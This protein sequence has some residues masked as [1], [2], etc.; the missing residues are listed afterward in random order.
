MIIPNPP[1]TLSLDALWISSIVLACL[2]GAETAL[3]LGIRLR[4]GSFRRLMRLA[5]ISKRHYKPADKQNIP[6]KHVK[7][8][9]GFSYGRDSNKR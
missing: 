6:A 7:N 3:L 5:I 9:G 8:K 2:V 4:L 1:S